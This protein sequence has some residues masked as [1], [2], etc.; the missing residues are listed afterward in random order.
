MGRSEVTRLS[1][2]KDVEDA[3]VLLAKYAGVEHDAHGEDTP[4][5]FLNMLDDLTKCKSHRGIDCPYFDWRTFGTSSEDMVV[6][7]DIPFA[8]VCNHH[9][10]PFIGFADVAYVPNANIAGLSKFAYV[11]HHFARQLQVQE[12]MTEQIADFLEHNLGGPAGV[13]VILRAEHMCMTIRGVQTP[14]TF[15]TTSTMRG[16]FG[17][18]KRTAKAELFQLLNR[19][20]T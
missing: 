15:T 13:A 9:I 2:D 4:R 16:V 14:G 6:V 1:Y 19:K 8:S 20:R 3:K 5:R 7:Q 10:L 11:V 12:R 18:H 17:E